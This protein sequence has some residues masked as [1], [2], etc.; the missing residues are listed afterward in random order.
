VR[1]VELF[2]ASAQD[3]AGFMLIALETTPEQVSS[4]I[5]L[6][7]EARLIARK[8]EMK[9]GEQYCDLHIRLGWRKLLELEAR[10]P[11]VSNS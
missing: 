10:K 6:C 2:A 7:N 3:T 4:G 9:L 8:H 1:E 11:P 5:D